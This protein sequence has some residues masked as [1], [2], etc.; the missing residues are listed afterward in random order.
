MAGVPLN[1]RLLL[2]S[3]VRPNLWVRPG[4]MTAMRTPALFDSTLLRIGIAALVGVGT[5]LAL[6]GAGTLWAPLGGWIGTAVVFTLWTWL[7]IR[8]MDADTVRTHAQRE[9]AGRAVGDM[10]LLLASVAGVVGVGLLLL[11][12][13][14]NDPSPVED[15]LV[16][17]LAVVASWLTTHMLFTLRYAR[18]HTADPDHGIDFPGDGEPTYR[19]F[20]YIAYTIGMTYQVSDTGIKGTE[21]RATALRHAL[22]SFFLGAVVVATTINLVVQMAGAGG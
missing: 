10:V 15:A 17:V 2:N 3:G 7:R 9:D 6:A 20:A 22:L 4:T 21:V 13:S 12:S 18:I 16:G 1:H 14:H 19:D 11:A 8:G 5:W